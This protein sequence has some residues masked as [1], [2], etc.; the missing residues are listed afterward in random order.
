MADEPGPVRELADGPDVILERSRVAPMNSTSYCSPAAA[1]RATCS[2]SC[3]PASVVAKWLRDNPEA[4]AG[5]QHSCTP[6][7]AWSY[8]PR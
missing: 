2:A 3:A 6:V 1:H 8:E 4:R 5:I 7:P